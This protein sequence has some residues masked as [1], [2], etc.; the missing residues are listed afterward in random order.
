MSEE[1]FLHNI[2]YRISGAEFGFYSSEE[3]RQSSVKEITNPNAFDVNKQPQNDGLY[4]PAMGV[5]PNDRFAVCVTCGQVG[6]E[7]S[8]HFGHLELILPVYNPLVMDKLLQLLKLK[9]QGCHKF[10]MA[11]YTISEYE[12]VLL[13]LKKG[14]LLESS[15]L[16]ETLRLER[17]LQR[18]KKRHEKEA[19]KKDGEKVDKSIAKLYSRSLE[20]AQ[21][22]RAQLEQQ[23]RTQPLSRDA[24]SF[25]RDLFGNVF[26]EFY[27]EGLAKCPHCLENYRGI[28]KEG[29][30]KIFSLVGQPKDRRK[31]SSST[32][33]G[34]SHMEEETNP[35]EKKDAKKQRY[36]NPEEVYRG[37]KALWRKEPR[38]MALIFGNG[39]SSNSF[40]MFFL[41]V[42]VVPPNRFRPESKLGEEKFLHDH[43]VVL[44]NVIKANKTIRHLLVTESLEGAGDERE[45]KGAYEER[46]RLPLLE[47]KRTAWFRECFE[48]LKDK[49]D[50][51][52]K[53]LQLQDY[54]NIFID[55]TK[56]SKASDREL[57]GLRQ[58]LEKKEGL[59]RM[60]MMGKRVNYAAR[61]VISPDPSLQTNEV[62]LP[63]FM[64]KKLT[65]PEPVNAY[66]CE[67][68]KQY[69]INGKEYPG[70]A[71][72]VENGTLINLNVLSEQQRI[73]HAR[74]LLVS[75]ETKVVYRHLIT[76]DNVL[77]NRQP[78]LHKPSLMAHK[79]RVLPREQTLR[80]NYANCKSYNADFD[81]DEMNLHAL[82]NY[83]AKAEAELCITDRVYT[84]ATNG[85][86]IRE[87]IQDSVI[88][89]VYLTLR[90]TF[91]S[92]SQFSELLYQATSI[93]FEEKPKNTRIFLM[94]PAIQRPQRLWTGKQLISNIM[95]LIVSLS[96]P[97]FRGQRGLT[98]KSTCCVSENYLTGNA[99]DESTV[100]VVDNEL[101]QGIIDK[102]QIG[103]GFTFGLVHSFH[104]LYGYRMTGQ[105]QTCLTILFS[106]FLK[107]H[108]FSCGIDDLI[109]T[110]KADKSRAAGL[111]EAHQQAV[112]NI[113]AFLNVKDVPQNI[114]YVQRNRHLSAEQEISLRPEENVL[115]ADME[116]VRT[117]S[118][119]LIVDAKALP[120]VELEYAEALKGK[121][122]KVVNDSLRSFSKKFPHNRFSIMVLTGAKG[123]TL[124]HSQVSVMLGQ[125]ELEGKRVPMMI[126]GK[127][128]PC[129]I[130]YDPNPRAYGFVSDRFLTGLRQQEFYFHCMAGR[131]G[132]I[133]T[134]VKTS[135]SG[136]LQRCLMKHLETL[137]VDYDF[138]VR[139]AD[140][141]VVQ[142]YFGEDGVDPAKEKFLTELDFLR[143]NSEPFGH[144]YKLRHFGKLLRTKEV[145]AFKESAEAQHETIMSRFPL[146]RNLV[147]LS[148][149]AYERVQ[150]YT[151]GLG[152]KERREFEDLYQ[153]KVLN[154]LA[155]PGECIG[156][157]AAQA[158]GEPST[159][160]T[161]NT[162]HLA[163]HGGVNLTLGIP[164]LREILMTST[165][166]LKTPVMELSFSRK[167]T[168]EEAQRYAQ[169]LQKIRLIS[170]VRGIEVLESKK[171]LNEEGQLLNPDFRKR[172]YNV[173]ILYEDPALILKEF[174]IGAEA[175]HGKM[176]QTFLPL[177]LNYIQRVHKKA[178]LKTEIKRSHHRADKEENAE[179]AEEEEP[180][181]TERDPEEE[182]ERERG[183]ELKESPYFNDIVYGPDSCSIGL[184]VPLSMKKFLMT[185]VIERFLRATVM[186]EVKGISRAVA[187]MKKENAP[188]TIQTEGVNFKAVQE[189]GFINHRS[190]ASNDIQ[191]IFRVFGVRVFPLRSRLRARPS[192]G[193]SWACSRPTRWSWT[194]GTCT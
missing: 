123:S 50:F 67:K 190:I 85:R 95:R 114:D 132:L 126:S 136:Y 139:D 44:T 62:G 140:A 18:I 194:T 101:L 22:T 46:N 107:M 143:N 106:N 158:V 98:M 108:G 72:I 162:F 153:L 6:L 99:R 90:D 134:A 73:S 110:K 125:Q 36:M 127:T 165:D 56:A 2:W 78:T 26:R 184:K 94:E 177:L 80:M 97:E 60:K 81:G 113:A 145:R 75:A 29:C 43:T 52:N 138:T 30:S 135:R 163:G 70:A 45:K 102:N 129:F 91:L 192:C 115:T 121:V 15:Q 74:N 33:K 175:I 27:R 53:W 12:N 76:G 154:A 66:N 186:R 48:R 133:D 51:I 180:A 23:A 159:Q 71:L 38:L 63:V 170:L 28:K 39:E 54:V 166:K 179:D 131:E 35:Q 11:S 112:R 37:I 83:Q 77:F 16:V 172:L 64:A 86:P 181:E 191:A 122:Q 7:C 13:L 193:R 151:Q 96:G 31:T 167:V 173:R 183:R 3:V 142:F 68:L 117:L 21:R 109:L 8:G 92:K 149:K 188:Y 119:R 103:S 130:P 105:L 10:R 141:G 58:I 14:A 32:T 164:R 189:L 157:T 156:C 148:E 124:N 20:S 42:V 84:N 17:K 59:F 5:S 116:I 4:D 176:A 79:I 161:L 47:M 118:E 87:L 171:L 55:A 82:Q 69:I 174:K 169:E 88:A 144:K 61:S 150:Q 24:T 100:R 146:G 25:E 185:Q 89:A 178:E 9:C 57:K 147:S 137:K 65:F 152:K 120:E 40:E 187:V 128:L 182:E 168:E 49:A 155:Q 104:E 34:E 93:L 111:E 1:I 160:M 41:N 19:E